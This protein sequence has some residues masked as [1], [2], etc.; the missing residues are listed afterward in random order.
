MVGRDGA[1][2]EGVEVELR[3]GPLVLHHLTAADG[4]WAC[5]LLPHLDSTVRFEKAGYVPLEEER[6]QANAWPDTVLSRDAVATPVPDP[7]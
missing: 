2:L 4:T 7:G 1:P 3:I 6:S 5:P